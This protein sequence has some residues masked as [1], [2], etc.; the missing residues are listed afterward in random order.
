ME[1]VAIVTILAVFEYAVFAL[2]VGLARNRTGVAAPNVSGHPE[3]E[4]YFR[5]QQNTLERLVIFIPS[6]WV[7]SFYVSE[8]AATYLGAAFILA[9]AGYCFGYIRNPANR[10]YGYAIGELI[11]TLLMLGG[12][13]GAISHLVGT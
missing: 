8:V 12:I 2:M 4:R 7:F 13:G 3:F 6:L 10:K 5:V 1:F 11:N 9:R